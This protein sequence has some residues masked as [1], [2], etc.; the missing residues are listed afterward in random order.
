MIKHRSRARV[1]VAAGFAAIVVLAGCGS[2]GS[3]SPSSGGGSSSS[4]GTSQQFSKKSPLTLGYS[5]QSAQDPYWQ[6]YVHGI[7]HEMKK[8]GFTKLSIEDS[9]ASAQKQVSGSLALIHTGI[10]ALIVSPQEPSALAATEI[11]AHNAKIP[12]IVG[13]VGA[14]G[15]Y[16][17]FILSDNYHGG[18]LAAQFVEK[19]LDGKSGVQQ[20]AVISL[21]PTTSV[22]GPRTN[23]FTQTIA[24]DSHLKVV[25]NIS[26]KQ[27]LSGGFA[28]A[29]A[30]LSAHPNIAAIYS[31]NDSMAAGAEQ[32]ITQAGKD[33]LTSPVLVGFNGDPIALKLMQQGKLAADI[34][35][36][37]YQQ[38][39]IAVDVAWAY[40]HGQTPKFTTPATKTI[41]VPVELVTPQTLP[42]FL[43][44]VKAGT[45]Y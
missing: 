41:S 11:A 35:Q 39:I 6:G 42:A 5:I 24:K 28:A 22:N 16:D 25:A 32:A 9:Q 20:V 27:T 21:L 36:N 26:G 10:S 33:P 1:T 37:P 31:E 45:A 29:Q 19:Q 38:G 15:N 2:S 4:S 40:L 13:D 12:V 23:G 17:A 34:A 30:I 14:A 3:S 18:Q 44:R 43:K 7:Q 8:Y